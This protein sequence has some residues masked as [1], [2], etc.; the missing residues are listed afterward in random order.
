MSKKCVSLGRLAD[1]LA[2][3]MTSIV[4]LLDIDGRDRSKDGGDGLLR[5]L[6]DV[7]STDVTELFR[8][9]E[10]ATEP[11]RVKRADCCS[12]VSTGVVGVGG[13]G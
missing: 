1:K 11:A 5:T 7:E 10:A 6:E 12:S 2:L 9:D 13:S 8:V 4:G 3:V